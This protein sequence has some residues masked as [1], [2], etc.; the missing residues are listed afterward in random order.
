M[1]NPIIFTLPRTGSTVVCK[2]L[3]NI[4][5]QEFGHKNVLYE[6]FN[7][8]FI[9]SVHNNKQLDYKQ[10]H[11]FD[12]KIIVALQGERTHE[13]DSEVRKR[14]LELLQHNPRHTMKV[15]P[16]VMTSDI[17]SFIIKEYDFIFLERRDKIEQFLSFCSILHSRKTHFLKDDQTNITSFPFVLS[18]VQWFA[19]Q[20]QMFNDMQKK[21]PGITVYYEDF[22]NLGGD[23]K[24]LAKLLGLTGTNLID[25]N[26]LTKPT[27]YEDTYENLISN[28]AEWLEHKQFVI[29][30]FSK[31]D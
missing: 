24:A 8:N 7:I 30:T 12:D 22:M 18:R 2:L 6:Y 31:Y 3:G 1:K 25:C 17:V 21:K 23:Q 13:S 5:R 28:K 29:D 27:P 10:V 19:N 4:A 26:V 9:D 16:S 11:V 15:F 14:R 20:L